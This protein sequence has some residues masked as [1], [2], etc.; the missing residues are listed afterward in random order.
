MQHLDDRASINHGGTF[1]LFSSFQY[2]H[3][4]FFSSYS[5]HQY[6]S[7]KRFFFDIFLWI[8]LLFWHFIPIFILFSHFFYIY[9]SIFF[10]GDEE[11]NSP[12]NPYQDQNGFLGSAYKGRIIPGKLHFFDFSFFNLFFCFD[13]DLYYFILLL[14]FLVIF[15]IIFL[16]SFYI[17]T[18]YITLFF[19]LFFYF[20]IIY[21]YF[22]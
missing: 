15:L 17:F 11:P 4:T 2:K 16:W 1:W 20:Y 12:N 7:R 14:F 8:L 13:L 3:Y 19:S 5:I 10:I 9:F 18:F 6:F 22:L 21:I